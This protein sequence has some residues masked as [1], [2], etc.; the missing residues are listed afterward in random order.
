[1][2]QRPLRLLLV[3]LAVTSG[4][5][6][7]HAAHDGPLDQGPGGT[8]GGTGGTGGGPSILQ[9]ASDGGGGSGGSASGPPAIGLAGSGSVGQCATGRTCD[10]CDELVEN[11]LHEYIE[12]A[13]DDGSPLPPKNVASLFGAPASASGGPCIIEPPDG[14]LFPNNWVRARI[15]FTPADPG[16]TIFQIRVHTSRQKN[17]LVVYTESKTWKIPKDIWQK[18]AASTW[19]EDITVAVSAVNP[20][21]G[22]PTSSQS[23]FSRN[24][25]QDRDFWHAAGSCRDRR[26]LRT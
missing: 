10:T 25:A 23:V 3:P 12:P 5:A 24:L 15:R 20:S 22:K 2:I 7:A 16:Q 4:A 14:A 9:G 21:G 18:L 11:G 17:D 19:D 26:I 1:M 6:C 8:G 13:P